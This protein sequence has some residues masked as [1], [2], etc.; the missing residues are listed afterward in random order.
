METLE[1]LMRKEAAGLTAKDITAYVYG[2]ARNVL[3]E[4]LRESKARL[5]YPSTES[6]AV[7]TD[8]TAETDLKERRFQCLEKCIQQLPKQSRELL[9]S[10]YEGKGAAARENR[11]M[12]AERLGI[13]REALTL[14]VFHL[15]HG[16]R[17]CI[18]K[19]LER[20]DEQ[21]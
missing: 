6:E 13:S 21:G 15:K 1:R 8:E 2:V 16:L 9:P 7:E 12:L 19:C 17:E 5:Y 20:E 3:H 18:E 4:Y 11:K 10:Y 14:R